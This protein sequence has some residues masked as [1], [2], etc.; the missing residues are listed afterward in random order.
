PLIRNGPQ[1]AVGGD[2]E[3]ERPQPRRCCTHRPGERLAVGQPGLPFQ[4][5]DFSACPHDSFGPERRIELSK[6]RV[7]NSSASSVVMMRMAS[8]TSGSHHSIVPRKT[9]IGTATAAEN[10]M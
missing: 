5:A 1:P 2:R 6:I 3:D 10:G 8:E 4:D 9:R 7:A